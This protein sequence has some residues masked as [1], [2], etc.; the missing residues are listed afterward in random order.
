MSGGEGDD[1]EVFFFFSFFSSRSLRLSVSM[2]YRTEIK[3]IEELPT[4]HEDIGSFPCSRRIT[5]GVRNK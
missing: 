2:K 3:Y 5:N 1:S 4:H